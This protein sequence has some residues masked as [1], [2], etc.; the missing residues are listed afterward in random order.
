MRQMFAGVKSITS[1][2]TS[3][4]SWKQTG[5]EARLTD[6][7]RTYVITVAGTFTIG[8]ETVSVIESVEF[9]L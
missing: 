4:G 5:Y 8:G 1:K 6:G 3:G 2:A 9:L 7:G